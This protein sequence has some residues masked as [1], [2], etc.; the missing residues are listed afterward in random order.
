MVILSQAADKDLIAELV[1][2]IPEQDRYGKFYAMTWY[3][4]FRREM[5][6]AM[7]TGHPTQPVIERH[8]SA[9]GTVGQHQSNGTGPMIATLIDRL[10]NGDY[11]VHRA[12]AELYDNLARAISLAQQGAPTDG[13]GD[14]YQ[15]PQENRPLSRCEAQ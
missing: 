15:P 3:D 13:F 12:M 7:A 6:S 5:D 2:R 9:V 4:A 1:R 8:W 11:A 10:A 14:L